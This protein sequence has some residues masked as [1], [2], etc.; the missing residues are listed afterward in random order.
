MMR[1]QGARIKRGLG[2]RCQ[3]SIAGPGQ[4]KWTGVNQE[5]RGDAGKQAGPHR[6]K[7]R[8]WENDASTR[9]TRTECHVHRL[10]PGSRV[11]ST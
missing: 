5:G 2:G 3:A 4:E 11:G 8:R 9:K 7:G 6:G 10:R 1:P